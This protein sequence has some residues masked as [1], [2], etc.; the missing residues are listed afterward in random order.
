MR[1][2]KYTK[3]SFQCIFQHAALRKGFILL[4]E[5][6]KQRGISHQLQAEL[7]STN[8]AMISMIFASIKAFARIMR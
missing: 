7:I 5:E 1:Q 3:K 4:N 2:L 6:Q 8:N